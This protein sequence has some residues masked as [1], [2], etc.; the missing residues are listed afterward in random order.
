MIVVM[1][2]YV[3][4]E[5]LLYVWWWKVYFFCF[6]ALVILLVKYE[7]FINL[8]GFCY[9]DDFRDL[10]LLEGNYNVGKRKSYV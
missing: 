4:V 7:D 8:I 5:I 3:W 2:V 9:Y 10:W 6:D 1:V